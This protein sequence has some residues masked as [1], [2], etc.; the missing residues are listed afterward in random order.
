MTFRKGY[1]TSS[2]RESD[3]SLPANIAVRLG[4]ATV[5]HL[6]MVLVRGTFEFIII[7]I[8]MPCK[9]SM[10]A[11]VINEKSLSVKHSPSY[12]VSMNGAASQGAVDIE[13]GNHWQVSLC[14]RYRLY[15]RSED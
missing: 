10:A 8:A 14:Q 12:A 3:V 15:S 7:T 9:L 5:P 2:R 1:R 11:T 4:G 6:R 13:P